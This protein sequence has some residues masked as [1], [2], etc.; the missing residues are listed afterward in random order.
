MD[1]RNKMIDEMIVRLEWWR[2]HLWYQA[3]EVMPAIDTIV[4]EVI[5]DINKIWLKYTEK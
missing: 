2:S 5:K 3:P 4:E 1:N